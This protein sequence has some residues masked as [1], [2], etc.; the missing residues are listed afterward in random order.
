ME[1]NIGILGEFWLL[2]KYRIGFVD[3]VGASDRLESSPHSTGL[4]QMVEMTE[5]YVGGNS[6]SYLFWRSAL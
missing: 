5:L 4:K 6:L 1:G 3:Q 2:L